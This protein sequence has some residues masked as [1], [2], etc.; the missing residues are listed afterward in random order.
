MTKCK[1]IEFINNLVSIL[2]IIKGLFT[3]YNGERVTLGNIPVQFEYTFGY[4]L[5]ARQSCHLYYNILII[6]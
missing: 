4:S 3:I 2:M 6:L 5:Y 1:F